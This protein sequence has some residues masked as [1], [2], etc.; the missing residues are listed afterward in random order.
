[1]APNR[2]LGWLGIRWFVSVRPGL[3]PIPCAALY[4]GCRC[5]F[6]ASLRDPKFYSYNSLGRPVG[7]SVASVCQ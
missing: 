6:I 1:M 2:R 4:V 7:D 3:V 5:Q